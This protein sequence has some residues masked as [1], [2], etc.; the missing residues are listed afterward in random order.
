MKIITGLSN[1]NL[2]R[3][4][5]NTL[6]IELLSTKIENFHDGELRVQVD[7]KIGIDVMIVQ[8]TSTPANDHLMELLLLA[9]TARRA[10]AKNIIAVIPYFGY[11]R[12]DRC[13]Y[14]HGPVSSSLVIRMIE[15]A[16]IRHVV[17]LDLH[18]PQLEG[19]FAIPVANLSTES[20][21]LPVGLNREKAIIVSPDIGGIPRARNYSSLFGMDLVIV[22]KTRD[23]NNQCHMSDVIGDVV[24][25]E[26]IIVD[27]IVDGKIIEQT[28]EAKL[29]IY[30]KPN[31]LITTHKDPNGRPTIFEQ[32]TN[33]PRVI[34]VG[35]LDINSEGLLLLTNNGELSRY[36][37]KPQNKIE[38]RYKVRVY[39]I[40][41]PINITNKKIVINGISYH[42]K[43]I[44]LIKKS[45]NNTCNSWY[46]VILTEGKNREIR[47]IFEYF[48]FKVNRLIRT[49]F[50]SYDLDN[51]KQ[52]EYKEVTI[53]ENYRWQTQK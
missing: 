40:K 41:K 47:K 34:S 30:Y 24:G 38:R 50:G 22:N 29:W 37:E 4:I 49:R 36:L 1:P 23:K 18:S 14:K 46:E 44:K 7:G 39:G 13:T 16:G 10:G 21:F 51:M 45:L 5:A 53:D 3:K 27:D 17:T 19:M 32:L 20:I 6:E 35:R 15:T 28:P 8:S 9:D 12:Q 2:A 42:P 43:S 33:I 26:C 31:G 11:S 48:G 52:G 25:M